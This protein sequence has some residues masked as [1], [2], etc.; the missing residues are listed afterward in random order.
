ARCSRA[1]AAKE[2]AEERERRAVAE[3]GTS[4]RHVERLRECIAEVQTEA[5]A[6]KEEAASFIRDTQAMIQLTQ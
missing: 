2:M 4:Q 1:E 3:L 5:A 6:T